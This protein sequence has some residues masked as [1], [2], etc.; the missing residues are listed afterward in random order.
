MLVWVPYQSY[1]RSHFYMLL[2]LSCLKLLYN[3]KWIIVGKAEIWISNLPVLD[4]ISL[5][6][7]FIKPQYFLKMN[8]SLQC[9]ENLKIQ[10]PSF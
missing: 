5:L 2:W 6:V 1:D 9:F 8:L 3:P 10:G 7:A 4:I